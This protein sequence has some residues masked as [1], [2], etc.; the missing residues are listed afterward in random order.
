[1]ITHESRRQKCPQCHLVPLSISIKIISKAKT[2]ALLQQFPINIIKKKKMITLV[3]VW[4]T[5]LKEL[6]LVSVSYWELKKYWCWSWEC[7]QYIN[8]WN[9][10]INDLHT[11]LRVEN[12]TIP[13]AV[14]KKYQFQIM[15]NILTMIKYQIKIALPLKVMQMHYKETGY[16]P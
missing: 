14:W 4:V 3:F 5:N 7:M 9:L 13:S 16:F 15:L 6:V 12:L 2:S 10:N 11:V 8:S 1:M